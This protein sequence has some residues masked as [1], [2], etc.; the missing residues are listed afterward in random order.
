MKFIAILAAAGCVA[1]LV[2]SNSALAQSMTSNEVK[3][4]SISKKWRGTPGMVTIGPDG[5]VIFLYG[6]TQ[7][8]VVCSPLQVCDIEL[9]GGEIVR[10]VLVGDTVRWKVEPATS[11]ATGGQAIHLIVKPAEAGLVTSMVV[12]TSRRTYHIQLK[13]HPSQY[14]ARV[15]FEYP[16]DATNKLKDIN[17]RLETGAITESAPDR[18]N[19]AYSISGRASW[20]PKRVYSD[21]VR[22]YIQFPK[23]ISGEDAP[24]LFVVSGGQNRIVNYRMHKDMMTVDYA[25]DKAILISGVGWRQQKVKI[26]RGG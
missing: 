14:M 13:S 16:E 18:L 9:Q 26:K 6:E 2:V 4:T 12:T 20:K 1:G 21:G 19:F 25:I 22:T 8:S 15:G 24:V 7:P 5:K 3:A 23:S 10:D 17:A 11:G